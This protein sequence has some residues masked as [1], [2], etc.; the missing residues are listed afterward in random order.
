MTDRNCDRSPPGA[1]AFDTGQITE[2]IR[3]EVGRPTRT[4]KRAQWVF[5]HWKQSGR[6]RSMASG[7]GGACRFRTGEDR[8]MTDPAKDG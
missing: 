7:R 8:G 2:V 4:H 3:K 5:L 1:G 6:R